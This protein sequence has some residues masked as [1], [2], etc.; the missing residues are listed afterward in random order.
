MPNNTAGGGQVGRGADV[1]AF[2]REA[3]RATSLSEL[4]TLLG[5]AAADMGFAYFALGHHV[6]VLSDGLVR[7]GNCPQSW[8]ESILSCGYMSI[9]PA[10]TTCRHT[11]VGFCWSEIPER[12]AL[13]AQQK[14]I[15]EEALLAGFGEGYTIPIHTSGE[16]A[17]SCSFVTSI[18]V[19]IDHRAIP[20]AHY[21]GCFAFEVARRLSR[22]PNGHPAS[23]GHKRVRPLSG[24]QLDCIVLAAQGKSD[25]DAGVLL[26]ISNQTVHQ[27]IETAKRRYGVATRTQLVVRALF[28]S[29]LTFRDVISR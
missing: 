11:V 22:T 20:A 26:G 12:I 18:G 7:I 14:R 3:N 6:S 24:R 27:H 23:S 4:Q 15:F 29:Q 8:M 28:D 13:T 1:Q 10:L 21:V 19:E 16:C 17:A 9:D 2:V 5:E 25:T